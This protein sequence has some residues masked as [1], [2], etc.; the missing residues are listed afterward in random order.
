MEE[1]SKSCFL[2]KKK[3]G[4][5]WKIYYSQKNCIEYEA[6]EDNSWIKGDILAENARNNFFVLLSSND[7]VYVFFQDIS[8][9]V[10]LTLFNDNNW[11]SKVIFKSKTPNSYNIKLSAIFCKNDIH[12]FYTV[13]GSSNPR[14]ALVHQICYD[15]KEWSSP[16]PIDMLN[17]KTSVPFIPFINSNNVLIFYE[18]G[19]TLPEV[20]YRKFS[21]SSNIWSEFISFD[22]NSLG[23]NDFSAAALNNQIHTLYIKRSETYSALIYNLKN[24]KTSRQIMLSKKQELN[25][26]IL[27]TLDNHIWALWYTGESI[28]GSYSTDEGEHFSTPA[29][30]YEC[31]NTMIRKVSFQNNNL[32]LLKHLSISHIFIDNI[33]TASILVIPDLYPAILNID[34]QEIQDATPSDENAKIEMHLNYIKQHL[35]DAYEKIFQYQKE[36]REKDQSII[37]LNSSL[38]QKSNDLLNIQYSLKIMKEKLEAALL[39]NQNINK[40]MSILNSKLTLKENQINSLRNTLEIQ[41]KE[42]EELNQN[43]SQTHHK[44]PEIKKSENKTSFLERIF[45][46][47]SI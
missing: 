21:T 20:G 45:N 22:K 43:K 7:Y 34:K 36:I 2:I 23:F 46:F 14:E 26:C 40:E 31:K 42:L 37:K 25:K 30:L 29:V 28:Y 35:N 13:K 11:S 5:L 12:V 10:V 33:D 6:Y 1:E 3:N 8:G 24:S 44:N 18:K 17:L 41:T 47:F 19:G 32:E 27:L 39:Q 15:E 4:A 16:R 9:N 38:E